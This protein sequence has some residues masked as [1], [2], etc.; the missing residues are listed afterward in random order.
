MKINEK[1]LQKLGS[2]SKINFSLKERSEMLRDFN[3]MV[4][5]IKSLDSLETADV[6]PLTHIHEQSNIFRDDNIDAMLVKSEMLR[7]AP[8]SNSDYIKVPKVIEK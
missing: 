8:K 3:K 1:V 5:F 7:N 2:L 4:E 6:K